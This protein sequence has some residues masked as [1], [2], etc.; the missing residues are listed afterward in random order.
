MVIEFL[1]IYMKNTVGILI[2][3][4]IKQQ[5]H[6]KHLADWTVMHISFHISF[7]IPYPSPRLTHLNSMWPGD[8]FMPVLNVIIASDN[9]LVYVQSQTITW[10]NGDSLS[11]ILQQCLLT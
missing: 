4:R 7:P 6:H 2:M 1:N 11:I 8:R 3:A 9:G 5:V 10:I